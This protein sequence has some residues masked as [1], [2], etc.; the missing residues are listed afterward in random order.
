MNKIGTVIPSAFPA[1]FL[2]TQLP[3]IVTMFSAH[4]SLAI[5]QLKGHL[6]RFARKYMM[7]QKVPVGR[8]PT[9]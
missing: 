4:K 6:V 3:H 1:P 9:P 2:E 8:L 5:D 7:D